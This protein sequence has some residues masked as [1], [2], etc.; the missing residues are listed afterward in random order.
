MKS[1]LALLALTA[2]VMA[3][4]AVSP[5]EA[6]QNEAAINNTEQ[7][8]DGEAPAEEGEVLQSTEGE[9][10]EGEAEE[11]EEAA[12]GEEEGEGEEGEEGEEEEGEGDEGE[13]ESV[14]EDAD[15]AA[16]VL[17]S[18]CTSLVALAAALF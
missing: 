10:V 5:D 6:A 7:T 4:Q 11:G 13:D 2:T 1:F 9:G 14:T 3:Q 17:V 18:T 16:G 8:A 15:S 12:E